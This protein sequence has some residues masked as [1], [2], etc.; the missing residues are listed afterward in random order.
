MPTDPSLRHSTPITSSHLKPACYR[1]GSPTTLPLF[2]PS[3]FHTTHVYIALL[4]KPLPQ[5]PHLPP[6]YSY[7]HRTLMI[8]NQKIPDPNPPDLTQLRRQLS[9]YIDGL[10]EC[11]LI[12]EDAAMSRH[13]WLLHLKLIRIRSEQPS[14][15][16]QVSLAGTPVAGHQ[17]GIPTI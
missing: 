15:R 14:N 1:H 9:P 16:D 11:S 10:M 13:P 4:R 17:G 12:G 6:Y 8:K 7:L 5:P 3:T 2:P